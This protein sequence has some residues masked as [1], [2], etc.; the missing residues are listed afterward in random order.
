MNRITVKFDMRISI[1]VIRFLFLFLTL[2]LLSAAQDNYTYRHSIF[3]PG[4]QY[5]ISDNQLVELEQLIDSLYQDNQ[6]EITI[7]SHTDNIGGET[8]NQWLSQMRSLSTKIHLEEFGVS[9]NS[10]HIKDFGQHN[11]IYDNSTFEG[12][13]KNRRV[14]IIFWPLSL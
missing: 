13:L 9:E 6:F 2:P 5:F 14:D 8:Y 10:M 7:H 11:P 1:M 4:G 3:F 12:R